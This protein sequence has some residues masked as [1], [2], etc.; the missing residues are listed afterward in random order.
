MLEKRRIVGPGVNCRVGSLEKDLVA[1]CRVILVNCR[2]GSLES[3]ASIYG[4]IC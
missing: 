3:I 2:V 4:S 1:V